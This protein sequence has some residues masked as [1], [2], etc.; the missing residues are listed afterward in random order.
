MATVNDVT[1]K[2]KRSTAASTRPVVIIGAGIQG[3]ATAFF[4]AS[5]D[6][7]SSCSTRTTLGAMRRG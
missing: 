7:R 3:C 2:V 4:L 5:G 1:V 6:S